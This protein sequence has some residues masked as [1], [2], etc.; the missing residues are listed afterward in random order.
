MDSSNS[1]ETEDIL[2][3]NVCVTNKDKPC[4]QLY[5][6]EYPFSETPAFLQIMSQKHLESILS[7][8]DFSDNSM[9]DA[10]QTDYTKY[11]LYMPDRLIHF[12]DA[13]L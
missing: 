11:G 13:H 7:L 8:L 1:V 4:L 6:T 2:G 12:N 10:K 3:V 9:H 5:W